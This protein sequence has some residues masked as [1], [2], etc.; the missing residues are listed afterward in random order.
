VTEPAAPRGKRRRK[1]GVQIR[2]EFAV[3]WTLYQL[4]RLLPMPVIR[5]VIRLL[6]LPLFLFFGRRRRITLDNIRHALGADHSEVEIE[7]IARASFRSFCLTVPEVVKLRDHLRRPDAQTWMERLDADL[8][9]L[10]RKARRI[11]DESRGC[12]FV[13]PHLGNWEL[14]P[15]VSAAVGIPLVVVVRPLDNE[16]LERLL[17]ESRAGTGQ[18]FIPKRNSLLPLQQL[19]NQGKSIGMLPDQSTM[20]GL[21][22]PFFGRLAWTTPV[23]ALLAIRNRRPIVVVACCRGGASGWEGF[24]SDPIWPGEYASYESEKNELIRLTT[25]MTAAMETV[26][27]RYPDQ[28]FW[29]HNRWKTYR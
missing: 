3:V 25:E 16:Y 8:S 29:M 6:E 19:L 14:L 11:H 1:S 23:P 10:F 24:V 5:G 27:R 26:I 12:I 22:V 15:Y 4:T 21:S 13:T 17:Y 2:V 20:K 7:G 28:Y 9:P 18:V